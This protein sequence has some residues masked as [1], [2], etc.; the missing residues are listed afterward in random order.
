MRVPTAYQSGYALELS[1]QVQTI[2]IIVSTHCVRFQLPKMYSSPAAFSVMGFFIQKYEFV[3]YQKPVLSPVRHHIQ[4]PIP[5][6]IL[7]QIIHGMFRN[8]FLLDKSFFVIIKP[9]HYHILRS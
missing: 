3:L 7:K 4:L 5:L 2:R 1:F 6:I 9:C 8:V